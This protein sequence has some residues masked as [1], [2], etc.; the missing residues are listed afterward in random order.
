MYSRLLRRK[1]LITS[2]VTLLATDSRHILLQLAQECSP[3]HPLHRRHM[4]RVSDWDLQGISFC[5]GLLN[6]LHS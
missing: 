6:P 5:Q 1:A 4:F 3:L 2:F